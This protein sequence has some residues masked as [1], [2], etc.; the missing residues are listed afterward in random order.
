MRSP[1]RSHDRA[2]FYKYTS[3]A[4]AKSIL[5]RQVLRWSSPV[6]FNDPFDIPR[7]AVLGFS[8]EEL[9]EASVT[10]FV[11]MLR[12]GRKPG[13]PI[14][15]TMKEEMQRLRIPPEK[16]AEIMRAT[17]AV[18]RARMEKGLQDF[19]SIWA[20]VVPRL[21]VLCMSEIMD[22]PSMWAHYADN[23]RGAAL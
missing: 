12:D 15:A 8:V 23:H 17:R 10:E 9:L 5:S 20:D 21:R 1:N 13:S 3:T 4:A 19:T 2:T 18:G 14:F 16:V 11:A 6:M 7:T 22:G